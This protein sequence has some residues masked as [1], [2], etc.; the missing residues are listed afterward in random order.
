MNCQ[1]TKGKQVVRKHTSSAGKAS[2][3]KRRRRDNYHSMDPKQKNQLLSRRAE[4][5]SN[6]EPKE[7]SPTTFNKSK[8]YKTMDHKGTERGGGYS[9]Y[10]DDRDDRRIF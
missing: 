6:I 2:I 9:L 1:I 10:S 4:K 5:Y 7:K 3:A 8:K